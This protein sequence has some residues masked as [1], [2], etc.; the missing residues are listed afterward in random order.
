MKTEILDVVSD[1]DG[2]RL[3]VLMAL[4]QDRPRGLVQIAHGMAEYKERYLPFLQALTQ[5]GYA[6]LI[7]DHRGHGATA[8]SVEDL[9]WFGEAGAEAL[10]EDMHQ[11]T[12]LF[13]R[14]FPGLPLCLFGHSMGSLAARAYARKYDGELSALVVCG[15]PGENPGA[16]IGLALVRLLE[17][18]K[19]GRYRSKLIDRLVNGSFAKKFPAEVSP[20]AWINSDPRA[21]ADYE[22]DEK[23]GFLFT[24]NGYQALLTLMRMAYAKDGWQLARPDLKILFISGGDD[25]CMISR[26]KLDQ[27]VARMREVGYGDVSLKVYEGLRH[28]ILLEKDHDRVYKDVLD[29]LGRMDG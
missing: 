4:P 10:V 24:L 13:K 15:C 23:C 22:K 5:A 1:F 28:E 11:L 18:V 17:K 9:G 3:S 2:L 27:A 12:G 20:F 8:R 19:G 29:F 26:E 14:R 16:G 6:C 25:P 7:G 21:V